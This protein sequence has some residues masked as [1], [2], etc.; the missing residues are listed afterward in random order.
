MLTI[1]QECLCHADLTAGPLFKSHDAAV[2]QCRI[3]DGFE[4]EEPQDPQEPDEPEGDRPT[5][6]DG[7]EFT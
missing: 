6:P 1:Y 5:H 2:E 3:H 4:Y 7:R